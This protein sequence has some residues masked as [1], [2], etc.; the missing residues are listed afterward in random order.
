MDWTKGKGKSKTKI[1]TNTGTK[2]KG[3]T[4]EEASLPETGHRAANGKRL[5]TPHSTRLGKMMGPAGTGPLRLDGKSQ[6]LI[7]RTGGNSQDWQ[8]QARWFAISLLEHD[9]E[10]EPPSRASGLPCRAR[11]QMSDHTQLFV[12]DVAQQSLFANTEHW[13]DRPE[14]EPALCHQG[15]RMHQVDGF[16]VCR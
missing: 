10:V 9:S 7:I 2:G 12:E 4:A 1:K 8:S 13:Y 16:P 11:G 6:K 14:P 5:L 15:L 3:Y